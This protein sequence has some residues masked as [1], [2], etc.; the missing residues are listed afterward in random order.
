MK[1]MLAASLS[2][3]SLSGCGTILTGQ[4]DTLTFRSVPSGATVEI[5]GNSVGRTPVTV[6]VQRSMSQPQV[7]LRLEG[8]EPRT[9]PLQNSFN[10]MSALNIFFWPGFIVDAAT[11]SIMKYNIVSYESELYKR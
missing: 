9:V 1:K 10:T 3:L 8:Y 11:G 6:P 5:N 2:M 7:Q 4:T